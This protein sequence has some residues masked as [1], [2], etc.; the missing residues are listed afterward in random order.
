MKIHPS[1]TILV[2][3]LFLAMSD[4]AGAA[5]PAAVITPSS[6][7]VA[8]DPVLP[9]TVTYTGLGLGGTLTATVEGCGTFSYDSE[10]DGEVTE[11]RGVRTWSLDVDLSACACAP[12]VVRTHHC[13]GWGRAFTTC[14]SADDAGA[15]GDRAVEL[16]FAVRSAGIPGN[17]TITT[18]TVTGTLVAGEQGVDEVYVPGRYWIEDGSDYVCEDRSEGV[19]DPV[20]PEQR[21]SSCVALGL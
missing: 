9:V 2:T 13:D 3:T 17:P 21:G 16:V 8:Q 15:C 5:H 4:I 7:F 20:A 14:E 19:G 11:S 18:Q 1:R 6:G 12:S 10:Y